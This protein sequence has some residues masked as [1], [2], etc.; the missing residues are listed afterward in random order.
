MLLS[1]P[2]GLRVSVI[3][4]CPCLSVCLSVCEC[5]ESCCGHKMCVCVCMYVCVCIYIYI[6][7]ER[8]RSDLQRDLESRCG[9]N[10]RTYIHIRT[11][12]H[13]HTCIHTH[14][15][16]SKDDYTAAQIIYIHT[17]TFTY[18]YTYTY[19]DSK[20]RMTTPRLRSAT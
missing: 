5:L 13:V 2:R 20:G 11:H 19:T 8:E 18:I 16:E 17:H 14:R 4:E 6:Y 7:T 1:G 3:F 12:S 9:H 10:M 15:F